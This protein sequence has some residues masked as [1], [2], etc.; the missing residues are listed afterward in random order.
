MGNVMK[1]I[2]LSMALLFAL[3]VTA[4]ALHVNNS[5]VLTIKQ[6][7]QFK[8]VEISQ[9]PADVLKAVTDK[10]AGYTLEEAYVSDKAVYKLILSKAGRKIEAHYSE[11]GKFIK[12]T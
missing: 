1:K 4:S 8:K 5:D 3:S 6:E 12:E 9:V 10:Y 7:K 2:L 11:T